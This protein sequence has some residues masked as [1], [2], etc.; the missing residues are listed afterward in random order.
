[1][2]R[3][4]AK[5]WALVPRSTP[6]C[7]KHGPRFAQWNDKERADA[8]EIGGGAGQGIA[9]AISFRTGEIGDL[10]ES[11]VSLEEAQLDM[12]RLPF[13]TRSGHSAPIQL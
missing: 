9:D 13:L 10:N 4:P 8:A 12:P 2:R 3:F 6:E 7:P 5:F 1:L 11:L